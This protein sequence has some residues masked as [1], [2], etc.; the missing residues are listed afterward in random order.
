MKRVSS[1]ALA[2][3]VALWAP[4]NH[5]VTAQEARHGGRFEVTVTNITAAQVFTPILV[6][7]HVGG[8]HLFTLGSPA[9]VPLEALA[10]A[11]DVTPIVDRASGSPAVGEIVTSEGPLPPGMS[12]TLHVAAG[13]R[14]DH[15]SV[16]SMLVPTN[17]AFFAA[18]GVE[19]PD[20]NRTLTIL[21]PAYDAGT[22]AN[23]QLCDHVPGPPSVCQGEGFNPS[24]AGAEGYV[25]V[26]RGIHDIGDLSAAAYDWRNPVARIT[27][28]RVR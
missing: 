23:D 6:A 25:H 16:A 5:G 11:G 18:N 9:S 19:G 14:F 1:V 7:S 22:E 17:D 3:L 2:T 8:V 21:S 10:E 26:H 27:I 28:R 4:A 24:R 12:V 13:G 15:V 20:G